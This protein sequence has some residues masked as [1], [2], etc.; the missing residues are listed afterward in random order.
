M[1]AGG[2]LCEMSNGFES[3]ANTVCSANRV[4]LD[5]RV[6]KVK[7]AGEVQR[8]LMGAV[9][10]A[11]AAV[12]AIRAVIQSGFD[13]TDADAVAMKCRYLD[14][15][16]DLCTLNRLTLADWTQQHPRGPLKIHVSLRSSDVES[17][18]QSANVPNDAVH[19]DSSEAKNMGTVIRC[20]NH[21]GG[22]VQSA[23]S[24]CN[25]P[26]LGTGVD[27]E[28]KDKRRDKTKA[29]QSAGLMGATGGQTRPGSS[30]PTADH[31]EEEAALCGVKAEVVE[32]IQTAPRH[33]KHTGRREAPDVRRN[34]T[35]VDQAAGMFGAMEIERS[36][37]ASGSTHKP[38]S[39][40]Y[41]S[42]CRLGRQHG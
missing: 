5:G 9:D 19:R 41:R 40:C 20:I 32:W 38:H 22:L 28:V 36:C 8:F 2:C 10:D 26:K 33:R 15:E 11:M 24:D 16:G 12:P 1:V 4:A 13:L 23:V 31:V 17:S 14:E 18:G 6:I 30:I 29:D 3:L 39:H 35:K 21:H 42:R 25:A 7:L 34:K 27:A 37:W